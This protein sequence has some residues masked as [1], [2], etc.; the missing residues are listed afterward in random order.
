MYS[1]NK[2]IKLLYVMGIIG[3][4]IGLDEIHKSHI[5]KKLSKNVAI[6]DLDIM[7]QKIYNNNDITKKK[8]EWA[9]ITKHIV[10]QRKQKILLG[11]GACQC[12]SSTPDC[13]LDFLTNQSRLFIDKVCQS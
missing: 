1:T 8:Q 2:I 3:H 12:S 11:G 6:I 4:I 5:I 7:Q 9:N 10:V 13:R